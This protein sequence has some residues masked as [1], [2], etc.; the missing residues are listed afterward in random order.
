MLFNSLVFWIFFA[1]V[2]ALYRFLPHTQQ[3]RMLLVASY[4]FYGYWDYRFLSLLLVSTLVDYFV[5]HWIDGSRTQTRK[6]NI[7]LISIV[8]NLGLLGFFKY[9][10]FFS[11]E[12]SVALEGIGLSVPLPFLD[13]VLPVGI[14]FYTFQTMSYTIDVY[15]GVTKPARNFADFALYV[16]FFPQ[17]V[18]GPIERSNHLL[19]Q[20]LRPR[21]ATTEQF[22]E[23]LYHILFG[24]F[25]K[26]VVA[27][28]MAPIVNHIFSRPVAELTGPEI[29]LGIYAFA[30]QIYGDFSGYSSIAQGIAKWMGFDL[31]WNFKMPYLSASPSEFWQRWHIS[32]SQWLRDYLYIPLGGNRGGLA[33]TQ[34]NLML[35][36]FLGGLWHGAAWTFVLWGIYHGLLLMV[37]RVAEYT[38]RLA[39]I[40]VPESRILRMVNVVFF[41]HLICISWLLFRAES[42]GQA[43]EMLT[44]IATDYTVTEMTKYGFAMMAFFVV[45]F[46]V[47]EL[48]IEKSGD[49]LR[50]VNSHWLFRAAVYVYFAAMIWVFPPLANQA[51]IYFQF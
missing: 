26:V 6:R 5:A 50:V 10:N 21:S 15:R 34:R 33:R 42:V 47:L 45:P 29:L 37:Y 30:F 14:S 23:G 13:V 28:N 7:L 3:N 27:D 39:N 24:L 22:I 49:L 40:R 20:I 31:S 19:P 36:M 44:V 9:Y 4:V 46:M 8:A 25:K 18:A 32:L 16:S 41:F 1:I 38:G 48:W 51:F 11:R 12:L 2:L 17:L 35:T 43:W